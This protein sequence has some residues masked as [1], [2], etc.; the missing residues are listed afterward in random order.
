[1]LSFRAVLVSSAALALFCFFVLFCFVLSCSV[2]SCIVLVLISPNCSGVFRCCWL[3]FCHLAFYYTIFRSLPP[4]CYSF[5]CFCF[6]VFPILPFSDVVIVYCP[7]SF[8]S[9]YLI[10]C[11]SSVLSR[12]CAVLLSAVLPVL[13]L[14]RPVS[15]EFGRSSQPIVTLIWKDTGLLELGI[16]LYL[17]TIN[18]ASRHFVQ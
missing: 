9:C 16:P 17:T 18:Q 6:L 8:L 7:A 12:R 2:S 13:R 10:V 14:I 15:A 1:M 11:Y 5:P 4:F 3:L